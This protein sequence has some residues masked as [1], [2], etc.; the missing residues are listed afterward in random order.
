MTI[1]SKHTP[2]QPDLG[3]EPSSFALAAKELMRPTFN[4]VGALWHAAIL[5]A[6]YAYTGDVTTTCAVGSATGLAVMGVSEFINVGL[7]HEGFPSGSIF[8]RA[9]NWG[10]AFMVVGA[11]GAIATPIS[12]VNRLV[13]ADPLSEMIAQGNLGPETKIVEYPTTRDVGIVTVVG[14][15]ADI[16]VKI[17]GKNTLLKCSEYW[18]NSKIYVPKDGI[19]NVK[20]REID[21]SKTPKMVGDGC[22]DVVIYRQEQKEAFGRT[23]QIR[24]A[25]RKAATP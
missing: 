23:A 13:S 8:E 2:A 1:S 25:A 18:E 4:K 19:N 12:E 5:T 14:K 10:G 11:I 20:Y 16:V 3:S 22:E 7:I 17:D 6:T 24:N 9:R 21:F 15:N